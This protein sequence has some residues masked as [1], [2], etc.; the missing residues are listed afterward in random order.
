MQSVIR[1]YPVHF[2]VIHCVVEESFSV[3]EEDYGPAV[4]LQECRNGD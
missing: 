1:A 4:L 3:V 2:K